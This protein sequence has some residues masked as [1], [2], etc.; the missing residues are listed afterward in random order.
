MN[1]G[2]DNQSAIERLKILFVDLHQKKLIDQ[3]P[4]KAPRAVFRKQHG[5]V[6][7]TFTVNPDLNAKYKI[8]VFNATNDQLPCVLR[9]SSDTAPNKND[10]N[11]TVGVGIKVLTDQ[12]QNS[13]F[14]G[15]NMDF[16][17]QNFDRFFVNTSEE[18]ADFET[19]ALILNNVDTYLEEH[20]KVK[21]LIDEMAHPEGSCLTATYWSVVPFKLGKE[22]IVKY[23][24]IPYEI[25]KSYPIE[26]K[27]YLTNDL[28]QRLLNKKY[29]FKFEL[30]VQTTK[31]AENKIDK[32]QDKWNPIEWVHAATIEL[33]EQD[34]CSKGQ[35]E[36]GDQLNFNIWR[37]PTDHLPLGSIAEAR[38]GVYEYSAKTRYSANGWI[39]AEN[40]RLPEHYD[41]N[42]KNNELDDEIVKAAI[43][44]SIGV[45]RVG[46]SDEFYLGPLVPD[47]NPD[48]NLDNY[49]DQFGRLKRQAAQFRIYGLNAKGKVVRELSSSENKE[50]EIEWSAHL[51]NQKAAWYEFNVALD[52]PDAKGY[53]AC[54]PRNLKINDRAS[55]IIDG[56]KQTVKKSKTIEKKVFKGNFLTEKD[57]YL[58]EM[59]LEDVSSNRL[60]VLG[61]KGKSGNINGDI[62]ITF[63]NNDGWYDDTS[64]GPVTATV[65]LNGKVI[66]VDPAWVICGPPDYAPMQK[67]VRTMWDLMRDLAVKNKML[68]VPELP[69]LK[70]DILPIFQRMTDLQWVNKGFSDYFGAL[71]PF[72]FKSPEW[73]KKISDASQDNLEFR[74]ILYNQFRKIDLPASQSAALWP[75]LYGDGVEIPQDKTNTQHSTLTELQLRFLR[76]W[77]EGKFINDLKPMTEGCP[78]HAINKEENI[79][80]K[81]KNIDEYPLEEQPELLTKAALDYCLADAFHPG[82]EITW[83]IRNPNMYMGAFRIAHESAK[84]FKNNQQ[85]LSNYLN[86]GATINYTLVDADVNPFNNQVA[87]GLTRWMAIPWQTDTSSCRDGYDLAYDPY[88]PTFWPARV[89]NNILALSDA[90]KLESPDLKIEEK[91][92]LFKYRKEWLADLPGKPTRFTDY[93]EVIN[94]M[95]DHYDR[96]GVV[97]K[98]EINAAENITDNIQVAFPKTLDHLV[99]VIYDLLNNPKW[100]S[101]AMLHTILEPIFK[102]DF[103]KI[104][105][106][107]DFLLEFKE[108]AEKALLKSITSIVTTEKVNKGKLLS[109]S[110]KAKS[111]EILKTQVQKDMTNLITAAEA[112]YKKEVLK[113]GTKVV[114][115][116]EHFRRQTQHKK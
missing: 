101:K 96:V 112:E 84:S 99:N 38:K 80:H 72:N 30:G 106:T 25:E 76:Q 40:D 13:N 57:I 10:L 110:Q 15:P 24:L 74:R 47:P 55:L 114:T 8:G 73:I 108:K 63:A 14:E 31:I 39:Y 70:Q 36:F 18:M 7:G 91:L 105:N 58:G 93:R 32:L 42:S 51:A 21:E 46:N 54:N 90:I 62:A 61:G 11:S 83:P 107:I 52:I 19:A 44:P 6:F 109:V 29:A 60:I 26:D 3:N 67:S 41:K 49:R 27:N 89:P 78:F 65:K 59:F 113:P 86:Y 17:F 75:W 33:L 48:N 43:Y 94:S 37:V 1:S 88:V 4:G 85:N 82:C 92:E 69:S 116:Q 81:W 64:D 9:F 34:I 2:M 20:K 104:G 35:P 5:V 16:I 77:M 56:K 95:V 28:Q 12:F 103:N 115:I 100:L 87:G 68:S 98:K 22:Y 79:Q 97:L 111:A 53:P 50:V 71:G 23:R 45:T 102:N 66:E